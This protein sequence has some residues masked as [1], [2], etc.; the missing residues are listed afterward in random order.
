MAWSAPLMGMFFT[1]QDYLR[2][3]THQI[4]DGDGGWPFVSMR[5][6]M[7]LL[8]KTHRHWRLGVWISMTSSNFFLIRVLPLMYRY[9]KWQQP[10]LSHHKSRGENLSCILFLERKVSSNLDISADVG[11]SA[12]SCGILF[13][14]SLRIRE[15]NVTKRL[16]G[17]GNV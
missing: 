1:F 9:G 5:L 8:F 2:K 13:H 11:F 17:M 6:P 4:L 12:H 14:E 16:W 10:A 15:G 7:I 3:R